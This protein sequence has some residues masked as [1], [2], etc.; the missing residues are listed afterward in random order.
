MYSG[1]INKTSPIIDLNTVLTGTWD[2]RTVNSWHVVMTPF[3]TAFDSV[4]DAGSLALPFTVTRPVPAMLF[5]NSG[6][7]SAMVIKPGD[8]AIALPES[9][10]VQVQVFGAAT[11]LKAVR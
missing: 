3:F 7:V 6:N 8:T 11:Q 1:T 4:A 5:G 2:E 9:G 10:A